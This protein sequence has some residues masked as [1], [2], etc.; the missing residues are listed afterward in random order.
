MDTAWLPLGAA[1]LD[2]LGIRLGWE[3]LQPFTKPAVML[4]AL[5]WI[6]VDGPGFNPPILWFLLGALFSLAGDLLLLPALDRFLPGLIAFMAAHLAYTIGLNT[7]PFP[8]NASTFLFAAVVVLLLA[9]SY[10]VLSGALEAGGRGALKMPVLL[11][12]LA[13]GATL[14]SGLSTLARD[15]WAPGPALLA[16]GGALLLVLSD[17]LLAWNR[18]VRPLDDARLRIRVTYHIGQLMLIGGALLFLG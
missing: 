11:Y 5:A 15:A 16:A 12:T 2:W 10:R 9:R 8:V 1:M 4:A 14:L 6:L 7:T 17:L 13:I 18:F 3:R